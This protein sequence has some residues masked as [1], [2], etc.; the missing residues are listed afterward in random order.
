MFLLS[1]ITFWSALVQSLPEDMADYGQDSLDPGNSE[2]EKTNQS[3][4]ESGCDRAMQALLPE[5][6][7][8]SVR[9]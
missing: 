1:C 5:L 4:L 2:R 7:A 3:A 6:F 8:G 9:T